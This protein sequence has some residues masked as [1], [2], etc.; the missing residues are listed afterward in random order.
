M[1]WEKECH[2][3]DEMNAKTGSKAV[4]SWIPDSRDMH[5]SFGT[6]SVEEDISQ[7]L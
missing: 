7:N 2:R 1:M 3:P 4:C 5:K 6:L